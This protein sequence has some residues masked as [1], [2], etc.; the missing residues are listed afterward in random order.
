MMINKTVLIK[1]ICPMCGAEKTTGP[2]YRNQ[3]CN[4]SDNSGVFF[5]PVS[6]VVT[7]ETS[8]EDW[9]NGKTPVYTLNMP[10]YYN[11]YIDEHCDDDC[12][13][14]VG[15][16]YNDPLDGYDS[17][18]RRECIGN[19][20]ISCDTN[21]RDL[22]ELQN[23]MV[24]GQEVYDLY[25]RIAAFVIPR[26]KY[27]IESGVNGHPGD[28]DNVD[29]WECILKKILTAFELLFN[30]KTSDVDDKIIEEGLKLFS[31]WFRC[32]WS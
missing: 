25:T 30:D 1:Q 9:V 26:L 22:K 17:C 28:L 23:N 3:H 10:V 15:C 11:S 32:M 13:K 7:T 6:I 18:V 19:H 31:R 27:W 2:L 5:E 16:E 21:I 14:C 12:K 24:I 8:F 29:E 4:C 20:C